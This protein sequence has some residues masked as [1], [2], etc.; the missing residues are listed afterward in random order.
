MIGLYARFNI[1]FVNFDFRQ[2][3]MDLSRISIHPVNVFYLKMETRPEVSLPENAQVTFEI[4]KQPITRDLYLR[5]YKAVGLKYNWVDR[6]IMP[7][8]ELLQ[9]INNPNVIIYLMKVDNNDAGYLELVKGDRFVE[10]LYFGL[11][12]EFIGKGLGKF[13]LQW[14]ILKAWSFDPEWIQLNTCEL[15]HRNALPTYKRLG[16][17]EYKT[18][19]EQRRV[20]DKS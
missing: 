1:C 6:F 19:V 11:F 12:P 15:D 3:I 5:Y 17:V 4:V 9:M 18:T 8:E 10:L 13:F 14:A 2:S 20:L 16:F 7:E